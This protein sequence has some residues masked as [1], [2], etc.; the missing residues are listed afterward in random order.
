[1]DH[2]IQGPECSWFGQRKNSRTDTEEAETGAGLLMQSKVK[3]HSPDG[4]VGRLKKEPCIG[5]SLDL[6]LLLGSV[7]MGVVSPGRLD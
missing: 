2:R 7:G 5:R 1:L 6:K 3:G 4:R